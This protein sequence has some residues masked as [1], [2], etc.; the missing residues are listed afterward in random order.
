[1][2]WHTSYSVELDDKGENLHLRSWANLTNTSGVDYQNV[3]LNLAAGAVNRRSSPRPAPMMAKSMRSLNAV[4]DSPVMERTAAPAQ[5]VGGMHIYALP[6]RVDLNQKETKQV[7]LMTPLSFKSK[8]T[9]VK[10]FGPTYGALNQ[11]PPHP[12]HP[13]IEI[14]FENTSGQP[15]P[16]G[17]T[18]LYRKDASGTLQFIGEDKLQ[19]TPNSG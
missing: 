7:A 16:A 1:L 14:A 6:T 3:T 12:V 2:K 10:R 18:R 19:Q 4:M 9:L 8:R 5:S 15:L 17:L 11:Q 13:D